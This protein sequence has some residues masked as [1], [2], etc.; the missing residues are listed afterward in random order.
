MRYRYFTVIVGEYKKI[1]LNLAG[2]NADKTLST[3]FYWLKI[4]LSSAAWNGQTIAMLSKLAVLSKK[5]TEVN[6]IEIYG[7]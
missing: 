5:N 2:N 6:A 7:K 1:A 3:R 4:R